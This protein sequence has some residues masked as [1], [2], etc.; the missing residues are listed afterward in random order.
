MA[1]LRELVARA[2]LDGLLVPPGDPVA[3]GVALNRVLGDR[4]L[5]DRL[6]ASGSAR[7]EEFSMDSLARRYLEIYD[8]IT[9]PA[10]RSRGWRRNR[11]LRPR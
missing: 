4:A 11:P 6:V 2:D 9:V 10:P 5:H 1:W 3:L 8:R 7:A